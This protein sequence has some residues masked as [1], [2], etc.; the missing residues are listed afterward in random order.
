MTL[1]TTQQIRLH[2]ARLLQESVGGQKGMIE[3]TGR[4]QSQISAIMGNSA[5]K[6]IGPNS[7][8]SL[9]ENFNLP[10]GWMDIW[11][12]T[13]NDNSTD[14]QT[15][16]ATT[17]PPA[18]YAVLKPETD[19]TDL[20]RSVIET[21]EIIEQEE[22]LKLTP[23]E[24]AQTIIACLKTCMKRGHNHSDN[25]AVVTAAIHAII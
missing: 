9:E 15:R 12:E 17:E 3:K 2:N 18:L 5:H 19:Q 13:L 1:K 22:G 25:Q 16:P 7:A 6:P 8:R 10:T 23:S 24:K 14:R 21:V 4:A 11:H 20:L